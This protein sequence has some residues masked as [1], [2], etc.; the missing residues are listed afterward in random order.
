MMLCRASLLAT[1]SPSIGYVGKVGCV[2]GDYG[3]RKL[4]SVLENVSSGYITTVHVSVS[5]A[6]RLLLRT[7]ARTTVLAAIANSNKYA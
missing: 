2:C 4:C 1:V 5:S 3:W 7:T 6:I